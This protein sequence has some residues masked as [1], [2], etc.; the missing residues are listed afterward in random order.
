MKKPIVLI[1][2][3]LLLAGFQFP[4]Q[5]VENGIDATG[6]QFVVPIKVNFSTTATN[7][8]SGALIAPSI[9]V[10]AGHCVLDSNGL[11]TK[12]VFVGKAGSSLASVSVSD[13]V[14]SIQIT[15]SFQNAT[16]STVGD[17]DLAFLTLSKP[18][19]MKVS[20]T[21]ASE[22]QIVTFKNSR[23]PLKLIGYGAYGDLSVENVTFPR[24]FEGSYSQEIAAY[25][26]SAY[27]ESTSGDSC[28]G[29]SG[30]PI[31]SA[32]ASKITIVGI[33]TGSVRNNKCTKAFNGKYYALFT[34]IGRYANLAFA[35]ATDKMS[36]DSSTIDSLNVR[37]TENTTE[38]ND[39][40]SQVGQLQTQLDE[41]LAT[42]AAL[43]KQIPK[44]ITC[45]KGKLTQKVTALKPS[46]PAGYKIK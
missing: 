28:A 24:A 23:S 13:K 42:I 22:A 19:E 17:D 29:D 8:C 43:Q 33:L 35:S 3:V 18:Q 30:A 44:T 1:L 21:L 11:V 12:D 5:A 27:L 41:A 14:L 45:V 9:V 20:V 34:L 31:I 40:E 36:Q 25:A 16:G 6:S 2:S 10:T 39:L 38:I 4:A 26:N 15:S 32:T 46:C 7:G 37:L